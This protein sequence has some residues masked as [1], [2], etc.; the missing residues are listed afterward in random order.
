MQICSRSSFK[1]SDL[2]TSNIVLSTRETT[3]NQ[4]T[5]EEL[6]IIHPTYQVS[7]NGGNKD[8]EGSSTLNF[9]RYDTGF[10]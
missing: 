10:L 9:N 7:L 4:N 1:S 5:S 2:S 3:N 8:K 6:L